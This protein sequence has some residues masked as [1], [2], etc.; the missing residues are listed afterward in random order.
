MTKELTDRLSEAFMRALPNRPTTIYL[1]QKEK[2]ETVYHMGIDGTAAQ[3]RISGSIVRDGLRPR[4]PVINFQG[5]PVVWTE[6]DSHFAV[7]LP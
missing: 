5:V 7:T 4:E 2:L 3:K 6:E 1:G